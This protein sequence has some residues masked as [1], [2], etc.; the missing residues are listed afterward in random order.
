MQIN[1]GLNETCEVTYNGVPY[2]DLNN[3]MRINIGLDIINTLSAHYGISVPIFIDNA[4]SVTS[5]EAVNGQVIRLIV[6]EQNKK[7]NVEVI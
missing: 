3:A 5:L 1:G 6:S 4:E 7:L 2:S